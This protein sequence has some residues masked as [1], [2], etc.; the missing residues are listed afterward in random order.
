MRKVIKEWVTLDSRFANQDYV[1]SCGILCDSER[2]QSSP[3]P[4]FGLQSQENGFLR[5]QPIVISGGANLQ[6]PRAKPSIR[7]GRNS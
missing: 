5:L 1:E 7:S 6:E 2:V 4:F 3:P